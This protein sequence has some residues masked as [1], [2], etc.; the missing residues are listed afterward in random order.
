VDHRFKIVI[1]VGALA[2]IWLLWLF[3][4]DKVCNDKSFSLVQVIYWYTILLRLWS[5]LQRMKY[6]DLFIEMYARLEDTS[7]D[8]FI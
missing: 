2:V 3:G 5:S 4:N 6:R 8:D 7:R 1:R